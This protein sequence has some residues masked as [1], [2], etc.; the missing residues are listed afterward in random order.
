MPAGKRL[1]DCP[2]TKK[3]FLRLMMEV[4]PGADNIPLDVAQSWLED[5]R[6]LQMAIFE[7]IVPRSA[8]PAVPPDERLGALVNLVA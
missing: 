8:Y 4:L 6:G 2:E 1:S 7:A 3:R 5:R